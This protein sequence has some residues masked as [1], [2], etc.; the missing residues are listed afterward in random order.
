MKKGAFGVTY[1]E[2]YLM[3]NLTIE[4]KAIYGMLCSFAKSDTAEAYPSVQFMCDKLHISRDRFY[5][6]V[7]LLVGA[8]VV[9]RRSTKDGNFRFSS[10]IYVLTPNLQNLHFP[11]TENK[12]TE[13]PYTENPY[14]DVPDTGDKATNNRTKNNR[15]INNR[16]VEGKGER[17]KGE[18]GEPS[19]SAA[20]PPGSDQIIPFQG[21]QKILIPIVGGSY[22]VPAVLIE[23]LSQEYPSVD[24][25]KELS[26]MAAWL[27]DN[28]EQKTDLASIY[29]YI[30]D[31]LANA[32]D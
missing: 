14:T 26:A 2:V 1:Q 23:V 32:N 8:G 27:R 19:R 20:P 15:T 17:G 28:P 11:Y 12:D 31:W 25:R 3:D 10:N 6:H 13:N 5:R 30:N 16:R 7:N 24:L 22:E 9:E 29:A 21:N 18:G 4:A